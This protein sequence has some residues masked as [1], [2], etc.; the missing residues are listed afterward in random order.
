MLSESSEPVVGR[1]YSNVL[2]IERRLYKDSGWEFFAPLPEDTS[3]EYGR[4]QKERLQE[5]LPDAEFRL[6]ETR[7][8]V[9]KRD[10]S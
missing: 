1:S 3:I 4:I 7:T 5:A 8:E 9:T 10:V 2:S 6:V